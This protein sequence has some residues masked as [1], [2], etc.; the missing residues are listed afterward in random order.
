M[1]SIISMSLLIFS[2]PDFLIKT[3]ESCCPRR[4]DHMNVFERIVMDLNEG[5]NYEKV[6]GETKKQL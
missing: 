4:G 3:L 5:S 1:M 6:A 2:P